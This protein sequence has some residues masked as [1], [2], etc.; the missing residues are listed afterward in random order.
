MASLPGRPPAPCSRV[1]LPPSVAGLCGPR[2][3]ADEPTRGSSAE[4][5]GR[6]AWPGWRQAAGVLAEAPGGGWC[7]GRL[8]RLRLLQRPGGPFRGGAWILCPLDAIPGGSRLRAPPLSPEGPLCPLHGSHGSP[9]RSRT[10]PACA[11][12][13]LPRRAAGGWDMFALRRKALILAFASFHGVNA[14]LWPIVGMKS[15]SPDLTQAVAAAGG[16]S[17][18]KRKNH[19]KMQ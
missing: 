9:R 14:S 17:D 10:A 5:A 1:H 8:H 13:L 3:P 11:G 4:D 2:D 19:S 15:P 7:W 6:G 18:S 16:V 12:P